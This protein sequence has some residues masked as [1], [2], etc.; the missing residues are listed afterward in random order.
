MGSI[1]I[2]ATREI[3]DD[4]AKEIRKRRAQG[5]KPSLTVINFRTDTD[6]D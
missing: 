6:R 3:V 5:P 4:F 2:P 1:T